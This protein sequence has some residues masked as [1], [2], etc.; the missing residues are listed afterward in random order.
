MQLLPIHFLLIL[1]VYWSDVVRIT[2]ITATIDLRSVK[3]I[4]EHL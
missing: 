2:D 3:E 1:C 4:I